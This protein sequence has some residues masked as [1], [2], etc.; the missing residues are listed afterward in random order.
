[1]KTPL[2]TWKRAKSEEVADCRIFKI[3]RDFSKRK[4]DDFEHAFFRIESS[5]WVNVIALTTE[6]EVVLIEQFRHGNEEITLEIPGGMIDAGEKPFDAAGRELL[7]ETGF[8]PREIIFLGK[9]H[10]NPAIQ[11]NLVHHFLALG[12]K[13]IKETAFD[14]NESISTKLVAPG[15]ISSLI[16]SGE[17][18]HSLV[19]AAFHWFNLKRI[20]IADK[21]K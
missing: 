14:D 16:E 19:I 18:T 8:S 21:P 17:I 11:N 10:P 9:S 4:S 2:E 6:N 3:Y 1:M 15:K 13:K 20:E 12:C 7:E 5:D